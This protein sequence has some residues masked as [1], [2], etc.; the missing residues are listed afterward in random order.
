MSVFIVGEIGINHNGDINIAKKLIDVAIAAGCD[1]VKFQKRTVDVVYTKDFLDSPRESPWGTTQREQKEGLE[2]GEAEYNAIDAY[3]Q[4]KGIAWFASTW[5]IESQRFLR[6]YNLKYNKVASAML[7]NDDLLKEIASERKLTFISTGMSTWEEIDHSVKIF[8]AMS[9]PFVLMHCN[10]TYPMAEEDANLRM[11]DEL[12]KRYGV[13]I[14]YSG[15][16]LGTFVSVLAVA[17]G[18]T[19]IERHITL[20]RTMYGSDQKSSLEPNELCALVKDI[21]KAETILGNGVRVLTVAEQ[22][23][24]AKLRG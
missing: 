5:D 16:E 6:K 15:H 18:A 3:C 10:S 22:A 21:R 1:A 17:A 24:K 20:D 11:I 14:G 7:V 13:E 23:V 4:E 12:R 19:A 2:F 9:C 8:Q